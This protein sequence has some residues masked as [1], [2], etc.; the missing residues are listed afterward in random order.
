MDDG[1][2]RAQVNTLIFDGDC[3]FCTTTVNLA[4]RW[5][6]PR[7][8][9]VAYQFADLGQ[10]GLTAEEC[11]EAVQWVGADGTHRSGGQAVAA[12]MISAPNPWPLVG[13]TMRSP[14][15]RVVV[16]LAYRWVARNRYR[17]PGSTPAC[18]VSTAEQAA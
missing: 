10:L 1:T 2:A 13:R 11:A 17:L 7:A 15:V 8:V 3:G 6:R 4:K 14:G 12:A 9:I 18:Q 5:V 16:D